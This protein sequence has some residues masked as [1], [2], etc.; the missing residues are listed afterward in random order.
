M[1]SYYCSKKTIPTPRKY[2]LKKNERLKS[3][4]LIN[5]LFESGSNHFL[6][7]LKVIFKIEASTSDKQHGML[8]GVTVPKRL[9]KSAV[10]RNLLKRRI[11]EAYR[12]HKIDLQDITEQHSIRLSMMYIYVSKEVESYETIQ[13]STIKLLKKLRTSVK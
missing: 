1:F 12:L 5:E 10:T 6:F 2:T 13:R 3:R 9:H 7:P 4:T 11:R 8:F